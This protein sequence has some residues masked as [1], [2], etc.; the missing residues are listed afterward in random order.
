MVE[1]EVTLE[2][3]TLLRSDRAVSRRGGDVAL[4]VKPLRL[5]IDATRP[6]DQMEGFQIS[7]PSRHFTV[8]TKAHAQQ[9]QMTILFCVLFEQWHDSTLKTSACPPCQL[10]DAIMFFGKRF[11]QQ[12]TQYC[13]RGVPA[14]SSNVTHSIQD[15]SLA[16]HPRP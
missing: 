15:R 16:I 12:I 2:S 14:P 7:I 13:R 4:Y 5:R 3:Y 9:N 11:F 6:C 8:F 10:A 1:P